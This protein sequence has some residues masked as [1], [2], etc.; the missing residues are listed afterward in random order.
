MYKTYNVGGHWMLIVSGR[1]PGGMRVKIEN[2][3]SGEEMVADLSFWATR[4]LVRSLCEFISSE[5]EAGKPCGVPPETERGDELRD[6]A[7]RLDELEGALSDIQGQ[8]EDVV[9][10]LHQQLGILK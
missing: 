8:L 4:S 1:K 3:A 10:G 5:R 2:L 6:L 7:F 9:V